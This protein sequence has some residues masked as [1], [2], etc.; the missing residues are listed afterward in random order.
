MGHEVSW[1]TRKLLSLDKYLFYI[2]NR[3][4]FL[5][6]FLCNF[7]WLS[8]QGFKMTSEEAKCIDG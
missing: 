4:L 3:D 2:D 6:S 5:A 1:D 7:K 8:F